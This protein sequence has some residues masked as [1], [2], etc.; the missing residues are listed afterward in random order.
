MRG[1]NLDQLNSL[2]AV[3]ELGSF[4]AAA[5][6]LAL[7]QPAVSQQI[8]ELEDRYGVRLVERL[9]KRA[10][11]TEAGRALLEH[12]RRL[13]AEA[14]AALGT[15]RR[16]RDGWLGRVRI[17]TGAATLAYRLLPLIKR[18]RQEHPT[19]ELAASTGMTE[20][21]IEALRE[22][23][24]DLALLTLPAPTTGLVVETLLDEP[25]VVAIGRGEAAMAASLPARP[26]AADLARYELIVE[27][28]RGG[29]THLLQNWFAG[30]GVAMPQPMVLG[31]IEAVRLAVGA[32]LGVAVLPLA[33]TL[34]PHNR[35]EIETRPLSPPLQ[36]SMALVYRAEKTAEESFRLVLDCFRQVGGADAGPPPPRR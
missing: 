29:V 3:I 14:E 33:M 19:L 16:Y 18:L 6:R 24:I 32:G 13:A 28:L 21:V 27:S 12:Q 10:Y 30:A 36:R 25:L 5:R 31:S 15:L 20:D 9:G 34:D 1:L 4:S 8:R 2:A 22:N 7:T 23:R 35:A 17:G 26:A 11:A